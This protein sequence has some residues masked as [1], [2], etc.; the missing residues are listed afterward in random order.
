[1]DQRTVQSK[2]K[3]QKQEQP[4]NKTNKEINAGA[5]TP[6]IRMDLCECFH[7]AAVHG[8]FKPE[9]AALLNGYCDMVLHQPRKLTLLPPS[10]DLDC[11]KRVPFRIFDRS[12]FA[13]VNE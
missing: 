8:G 7:E 9:R 6:K 1:M 12:S 10:P 2:Q 11:K 13:I 3:K 5:T 4:E